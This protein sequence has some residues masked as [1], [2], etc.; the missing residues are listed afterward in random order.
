MPPEADE[1]Q[2]PTS[3]PETDS[4]PPPDLSS[5]DPTR[6]ARKPPSPEGE[7]KPPDKKQKPDEPSRAR[8]EPS[9]SSSHQPILPI[10]LDD[11]GAETDNDDDEED[12][13][14]IAY[15]EHDQDLIV[16]DDSTW[17]KQPDGNKLASQA[18]SF[19]V[20]TTMEDTTRCSGTTHLTI[21]T[22]RTMPLVQSISS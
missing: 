7:T 5:P 1:V 8:T 9:S 11:Q 22:S 17:S 13:G 14:T 20:I 6:K 21:N 18:S 16:F 15:P 19:S 2:Q 10:R 4:H 12:R 3:R